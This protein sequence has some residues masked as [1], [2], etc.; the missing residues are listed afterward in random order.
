MSTTRLLTVAALAVLAT[1]CAVGPDYHRPVAPLPERYVG[2]AA[3]PQAAAAP[4]AAG[5][6]AWWNG[7]DDPALARY[8]SL[9]LAGN[10]DLAQAAARVA[11]ARAG[12]GAAEPR[13]GRP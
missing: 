9:A 6:A 13:Q 11:Q 10:L 12:L 8:V 5:L 4:A 7:F 1:G 2:Q 3:F